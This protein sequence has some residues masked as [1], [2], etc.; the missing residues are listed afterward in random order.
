MRVEQLEYVTA[1]VRH[2]SFRR[3]AEE[4]NISQPALSETVQKLEREL[5]VRILD[6]RRSGTTITD[7]GRELLP[8]ML[9]AIDAVD[10]LRHAA[11]SHGEGTQVVRLGTVTAATAPLVT[12][13]IQR[14]REMH[15]TTRVEVVAA[16]QERL[17]RDLL[18]GALDLGLVNYLGGEEPPG[19][20]ETVELLRGRPVA[21]IRGDS[22]LA[23]RPTV[24]SEELAA[25]PLIAMRSGYVMHRYL[26]RLLGGRPPNFSY[27][28]DGAE[29]GKL[30]VAEG[31]GAAVLPDYSVIGDPLEQR[32]AITYRPIADDDT[33]V[34]LLLHH[35]RSESTPRTVRDLRAL[36]VE[37][38]QRRT[39]AIAAAPA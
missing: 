19:S 12:P 6:R 36:F 23:E 11:G 20:L 31:L 21:C 35:R 3:A 30:M 33:E 4:M 25:Q 8:H 13:T 18:E 16:Q 26:V 38:A 32:G 37:Q 15:A 10:R 17:H 7:D 22:P 1:V 39:A 2:G 28:T 24:T 27:S 14:F 29:M 34:M 9:N 5:G